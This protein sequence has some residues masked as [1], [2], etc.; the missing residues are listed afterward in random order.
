MPNAGSARMS[1]LQILVNQR[2]GT[3]SPSRS[4]YTVGLFHGG[5]TFGE[6]Q[7]GFQEPQQLETL[8][9]KRLS[10]RIYSDLRH[11]GVRVQDI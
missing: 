1:A 4:G 6:P 11:Q 8:D 5:R 9:K 7:K 2:L 10:Q 3:A